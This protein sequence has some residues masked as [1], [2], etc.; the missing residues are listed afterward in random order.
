MRK[1]HR[2]AC[3]SRSVSI[4]C[5]DIWFPVGLLS[6]P[7]IR[8]TQLAQASAAPA[9]EVFATVAHSRGGRE[10]KAEANRKTSSAENAKTR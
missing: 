3:H 8:A 10:K 7:L 2:L 5:A 4:A 1:L 9:A 6:W